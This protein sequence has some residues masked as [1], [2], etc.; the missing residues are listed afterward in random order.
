MFE[1][2]TN[3]RQDQEAPSVYIFAQSL[4]LI[5]LQHDVVA[6]GHYSCTNSESSGHLAARILSSYFL[7]L[8]GVFSGKTT[9]LKLEV[10]LTFR[11]PSVYPVRWANRSLPSSVGPAIFLANIEAWKGAY[12]NS[13]AKAALRSALYTA[14]LGVLQKSKR[15]PRPAIGTS[16]LRMVS[17][18]ESWACD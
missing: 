11:V 7:V 5:F 15:A 9:W 13:S 6:S 14:S 2:K 3:G 1:E 17:K 16:E 18:S 8:P 4:M 10:G 12:S